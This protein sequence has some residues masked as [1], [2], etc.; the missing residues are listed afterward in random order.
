MT[1]RFTDVCCNFESTDRRDSN[2]VAFIEEQVRPLAGPV[3]TM[4]VFFAARI[5]PD[6][7]SSQIH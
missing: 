3:E 2:A 1:R 4:T 7:R 5:L 6:P